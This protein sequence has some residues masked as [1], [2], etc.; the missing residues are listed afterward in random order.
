MGYNG[1]LTV[2]RGSQH[3]PRMAVMKYTPKGRKGSGK[4]KKHICLIG[5]GVT[6]D[7]GGVCL[8]PCGSMWEMKGDMAGAAAAIFSMAAVAALKPAY[9]VTAIMPMAQNAIGKHAAL[10]GEVIKTP[11]GKT[12]HVLNTDAEGRLIM[13]D[14]LY[15]AGKLKATHIIDMATLTGS[16]VRAL[17]TSITGFFSTDDDLAGRIIKAGEKVGEDMWRMPLYEE[18]KAYLKSTVADV[19]NIGNTPNAGAITA[20]LF[21]QEFVLEGAAWA[22]LDIAGTSFANKKWKYYAPGGNGTPIKT[23]AALCE[24]F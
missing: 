14:A 5:K 2:G 6:F 21:L 4:N 19:N 23:I 11:G 24:D 17:G 9:P 8:K 7:S 13:S 20:A 1:T 16:I 18:Y 10:P 3:P 22:H 12:I 15:H